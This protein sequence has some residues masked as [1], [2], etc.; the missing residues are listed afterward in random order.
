MTWHHLN[1]V[2]GL[3]GLGHDV[4]FMEDSDDYESCYDPSRHVVSTD[5]S[6][7][8]RYAADV[9]DRVGLASRWAYHDAH[10]GSWFGAP[11]DEALEICRTADVV[12]NVSGVNP[13]RPWLK[14]VPARVLIDTDPAFTQIKHLT[15][16]SAAERAGQHTSWFSFGENIGSDRCTIPDDGLPWKPT[17][18]PVALDRWP[19][20][21][22][23]DGGCFTTVMQWDSYPPKTFEGIRYGMKSH[24]FGRFMD[25]PTTEG[26]CL[27]VAIGG[28]QAP[29]A[30][31]EEAG[32]RVADPLEVA[33]D[34]WSYQTYIENSRG[35]LSV[36]KE[37]YAVSRSGWFSERSALYLSMG[38]PVVTLETGF[39]EWMDV[40]EGVVSFE[41]PD[42]ARELL[43]LVQS[44]YAMHSGAA[45][46]V[47]ERYFDSAAVLGSLL[48]R[49]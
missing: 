46:R 32:W 43:S 24:S 29:R 9:F 22:P 35:E 4:Y 7:G 23:I 16:P 19:A 31:L 49:V 40:G 15:D 6:F 11:A 33:A 37:G 17:R 25:L 1:Y 39:S 36:A 34:P 27:E 10:S 5:P 26:P 42:G 30:A 14:D 21:Q 3:A 48:D 13:I 20:E 28:S 8:L 12:L 2:L 44:D 47:A 38:K 41:E 45:R 18:Q